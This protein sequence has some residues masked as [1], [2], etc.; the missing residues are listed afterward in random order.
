[1]KL[2]LEKCMVLHITVKTNPL[3]SDYSLHGHK[4]DSVSE[5]KYLGV[6]LDSK[7]RLTCLL[8]QF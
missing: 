1:M 7:L 8:N 2:N 3:L 5:A 6:L 4:L